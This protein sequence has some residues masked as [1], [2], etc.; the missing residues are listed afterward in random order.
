MNRIQGGRSVTAEGSRQTGHEWARLVV[1]GKLDPGPWSQLKP[2]NEVRLDHVRG[3]V[4]P[5][6][7]INSASTGVS[8]WDGVIPDPVD[9]TEMEFDERSSA[10]G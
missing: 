9:P 8:F 1:P 4:D 5:D 3:D 2:A 10:S 6:V 7:L